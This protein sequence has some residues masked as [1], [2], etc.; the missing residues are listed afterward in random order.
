MSVIFNVL[1]ADSTEKATMRRA[2]TAEGSLHRQNDTL[3]LVN[4]GNFCINSALV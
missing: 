3:C 4:A 1:V 2:K